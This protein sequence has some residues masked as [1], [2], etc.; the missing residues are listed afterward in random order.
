MKKSLLIY[1]I[2]LTPLLSRSQ[3]NFFGVGFETNLSAKPGSTFAVGIHEETRINQSPFYL[4]WH[5]AAGATY[6]S[7][8]YYRSSILLK[9]YSEPEYW[10]PTPHETLGGFIGLIIFPIACPT[11]IAD[12]FYNSPNRRWKMGIYTNVFDDD[13]WD[14]TNKPVDS[15]SPEIGYKVYYNLS[16]Q[17]SLYFSVGSS[18]VTNLESYRHADAFN[19]AH[20]NFSLGLANRSAG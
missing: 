6:K 1:F 8:I 20:L 14:L 7:D 12:Y 11:G 9:L 19:G 17:S 16:G 3:E 18:I 5:Y 4:T 2:C 10:D 15:W 13:F